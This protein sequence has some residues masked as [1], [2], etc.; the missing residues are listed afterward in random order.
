M[1][2]HSRARIPSG[3]RKLTTLS[4]IKASTVPKAIDNV[5][6]VFRN[7]TPVARPVRNAMGL[8]RSLWDEIARWSKRRCPTA[9]GSATLI[10]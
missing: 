9:K 8:V 2:Q 1:K 7:G 10:M 5:T 6:I 3:L 4:G